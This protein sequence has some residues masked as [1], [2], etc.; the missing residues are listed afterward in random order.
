MGIP[1]PL[2]DHTVGSPYESS[3]EGAGQPLHVEEIGQTY[4]APDP[5]N[6]NLVYTDFSSLHPGKY[7]EGL[8]MNRVYI[9]LSMMIQ[10]IQNVAVAQSDRLTILTDWEKAYNSKMN[11]VHSFVQGNNDAFISDTSS[12][13]AT[14]RQDL[15]NVN[16]TYTEQMRSNS[17]I[18]SDDAK[19]Q[20]TVINQTQDAVNNQSNLATSLVQQFATILSSI[21]H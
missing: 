17:N 5:T 8:T 18:V 11:S 19:A 7:L 3:P 13:S 20:Q 4:F 10:S 2:P 6:P 9:L 14:I 15:N 21:Y 12:N 16:S 1:N